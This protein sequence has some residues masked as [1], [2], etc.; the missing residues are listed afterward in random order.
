MRESI[1][2]RQ[3]SVKLVTARVE[4]GVASMLEVDQA[5]TL[6]HSAQA[7][8]ALLEKAQEQTENLISYLL[9]KQ[10]GPVARGRA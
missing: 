5:K 2:T 1:K 9:A 10:P 3:E 7:K 8:L 6:V 4:G